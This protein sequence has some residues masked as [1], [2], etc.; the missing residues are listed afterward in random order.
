MLL[1]LYPDAA[2]EATALLIRRAAHLGRDPGHVALPGGFVEPGEELLAAA[3]RE[4]DEEI[5]LDPAAVDVLGPLD[6]VE[7]PR[8][9]AVAA[10]VGLLAERPALVPSPDEVEAV[11][12]VP[13]ATLLSD[14]VAWEERWPLSSWDRDPAV[15]VRPV[16]FFACDLLGDDLVW[17]VTARILWDLLERVDR[18]DRAAA[19]DAGRAG[20]PRPHVRL[21]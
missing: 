21:D 18:A 16:R 20:R 4:A 6:V 11:L 5:G 15:A 3:L 12:D 1:A 19:D 8:R 9:G 2:G 14:G 7:R 10:F 17:G 13:L